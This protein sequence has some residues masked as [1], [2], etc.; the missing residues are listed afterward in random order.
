MS[1]RRAIEW[2]LSKSISGVSLGKLAVNEAYAAGHWRDIFG[3]HPGL[4]RVEYPTGETPQLAATFI[5]QFLR[6]KGDFPTDFHPLGWVHSSKSHSGAKW[7]DLSSH[8]L[9]L[10]EAGGTVPG[11]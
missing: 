4:V 5:N 9:R 2:D 6:V 1:I 7:W 3:L 10:V 8:S 11:C